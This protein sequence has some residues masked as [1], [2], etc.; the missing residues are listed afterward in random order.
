MLNRLL[1]IAFLALV[2]GYG[3]DLRAQIR[4]D[5]PSA[6]PGEATAV[7]HYPAGTVGIIAISVNGP[8][9]AFVESATGGLTPGNHDTAPDGVLVS[10]NATRVG[11]T[12]LSGIFVENWHS[13][14]TIFLAADD[15]TL[16]VGPALGAPSI[17]HRAGSASFAYA[18]EPTSSFLLSLAFAGV[19]TC[20]RRRS[21]TVVKYR[22]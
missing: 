4:V 13:Y 1:S 5:T 18:P 15:L 19:L 6:A 14:N 10:D 11:L 3:E 12:G 8:V 22:G 16:V 17:S 21:E 2:V 7:Y 9:N 20:R